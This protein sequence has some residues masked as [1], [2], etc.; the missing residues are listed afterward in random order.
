MA[1]ILNLIFQIFSEPI[2]ERKMKLT[3]TFELDKDSDQYIKT[4]FSNLTKQFSDLIGLFENTEFKIEEAA[5]VEPDTK[6]ATMPV[7][8]APKKKSKPR[9]S[10]KTTIL[11]AI[12]KHKEGISSKELQQETGFTG[13]QV[14][15]SVFRLKNENKIEKTEAGMFVVL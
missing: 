3:V 2:Q 11:K 5:P 6:P 10:N 4:S 12:K 14:S 1:L 7:K 15:N 9:K 13:K 8:Q